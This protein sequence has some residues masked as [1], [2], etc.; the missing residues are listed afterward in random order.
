MRYFMEAQMKVLLIIPPFVNND[1]YMP[2]LGVY[3][4]ARTLLD[5]GFEVEVID[6][7][8]EI[9]I[10]NINADE[11]IYLTCVDYVLKR[12]PDVICF[13]CNCMTI[14]PAIQ[15]ASTIKKKNK[16]P[17]IVGG[18]I[19]TTNPYD[20]I[21]YKTIDY[22]VAGEGE[23]SLPYLITNMDSNEK[24]KDVDVLFRSNNSIIRG[25]N[26]KL[27]DYDSYNIIPAYE[28]MPKEN[29]ILFINHGK[30]F[31][32]CEAGRGCAFRCAFCCSDTIWQRKVNF[33]D[34]TLIKKQIEAIQRR[35]NNATI[36]FTCDNLIYNNSLVG[37]ICD[38][39]TS[40]GLK[41]QCRGR[42]D[43]DCNY[44]QMFN[45]GCEM[46][47][48]GIE[49]VQQKTWTKIHKGIFPRDLLE[50][51]SNITNSGI[52]VTATYIIGFPF[53]ND[54][55]MLNTL[56]NAFQI[57]K[58]ANS[59]VTIH[60]LTPLPFTQLY[61]ENSD[62]YFNDITDLV[63][64]V[65]F[66][67]KLFPSDIELIKSDKELFLAFY[68]FRSTNKY[69]SCVVKLAHIAT[70]LCK[71]PIFASAIFD[72]YI[73]IKEL[74]QLIM[75]YYDEYGDTAD[76]SDMPYFILKR[77]VASKEEIVALSELY[78]IESRL[79]N[80]KKYHFNYTMFSPAIQLLL[81]H[82]LFC[83][84]ISSDLS[85][86]FES[87]SFTGCIK[88]DENSSCNYLFVYNP[89]TRKYAFALSNL[90]EYGSMYIYNKLQN[91]D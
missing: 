43:I 53:E 49:S 84:T 28:L 91:P 9:K 48:V 76:A 11:S 89:Q 31:I 3:V 63:S 7:S 27:I 5:S 2:S 39:M 32:P 20:I 50:R 58:C 41:W 68:C 33:F 70:N 1:Y 26:N 57:A 72:N 10:G 17:I 80:V 59:D 46:M 25:K 74:P 87:K 6:F 60:A 62:V 4:L 81:A 88:K 16:L 52:G 12:H 36:Y 22:V 82:G 38:L 24:L 40:K 23:H 30:V 44:S 79:N 51:V 61:Q 42:L 90:T 54:D 69:N 13:S 65:K 21:K 66:C 83:F 14:L 86:A 45:A 35:Y 15:M 77:I 47:M 8:F 85:K 55:D 56:C 67:N 37:K 75:D 29:D 34:I 18:P 78:E 19:A 64:G 71:T 73:S